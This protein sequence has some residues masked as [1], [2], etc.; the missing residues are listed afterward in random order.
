MAIIDNYVPVEETKLPRYVI[1][2]GRPV[3]VVGYSPKTEARPALFHVIDRSDAH[4]S[5]SRSQ[6]QFM[7]ERPH[8]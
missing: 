6:I 3:R 2:R 7:K 5:L 1:F 4:R 8:A